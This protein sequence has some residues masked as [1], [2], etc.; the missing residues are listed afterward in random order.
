MIFW[1]SSLAWDISFIDTVRFFIVSLARTMMP[2]ASCISRSAW[3]ALS[4]FLL[5]IADISSRD[6]LVSSMADACSEAPSA[7]FW[8]ED[9]NCPAA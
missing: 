5:V 8:L 1:V 3:L 4:A 9:D 6:E 7:S 2:V